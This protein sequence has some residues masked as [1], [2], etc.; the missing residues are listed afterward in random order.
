MST[1]T[2]SGDVVNKTYLSIFL[3]VTLLGSTLNAQD[4]D[5]SRTQHMQ[6]NYAHPGWII[7]S[8]I[9]ALFGAGAI[10]ATDHFAH[11]A[12]TVKKHKL[13]RDLRTTSIVLTTLAAAM[14]IGGAIAH[15]TY[16]EP[17]KNTSRRHTTDFFTTTATSS[18]GE[19]PAQQSTPLFAAA[20]AGGPQPQ[21]PT[22][23]VC[24]TRGTPGTL[25]TPLCDS[26]PPTRPRSSSWSFMQNQQDD[27][28]E[29]AFELL[30]SWVPR[31]IEQQNLHA[32]QRQKAK[33]AKLKKTMAELKKEIRNTK[34]N[35]PQ[36]D[37]TELQKTTV[38][39]ESRVSQRARSLSS[40]SDNGTP[41]AR[42][43]K[44]AALATA[45]N[46]SCPIARHFEPHTQSLS[47]LPATGATGAPAMNQ[48]PHV[49]NRQD[50]DSPNQ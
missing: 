16:A 10:A 32:V 13:W 35:K 27:E 48:E 36:S 44:C 25:S 33:L 31:R 22:T 26:T 47:I 40:L 8:G 1:F 9:G 29:V 50:V 24:A 12:S 18:G 37:F 4:S 20:G 19:G 6:R 3:C 14:G 23:T 15:A 7:G 21:S 2:Y 30:S 43:Y 46:A 28:Q 11:N 38:Q 42:K 45:H 17:Q 49:V 39:L 5:M 41:V 34:G